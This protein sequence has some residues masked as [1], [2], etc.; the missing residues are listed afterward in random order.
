MACCRVFRGGEE[1][2]QWLRIV[3]MGAFASALLGF[4]PCLT[5]PALAQNEINLNSS[6]VQVVHNAAA[7]SDVLNMSLNVESDGDGGLDPCESQA[8]DLLETGVH[9]SVFSGS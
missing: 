8:D 6:N 4:L 3:L 5:S 9:V 2:G 1:M 7:N